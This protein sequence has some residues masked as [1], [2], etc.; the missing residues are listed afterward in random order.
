MMARKTIEFVIKLFIVA[1]I[2]TA[3]LYF[4]KVLELIGIVS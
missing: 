1:L 4:Y 3:G 2:A